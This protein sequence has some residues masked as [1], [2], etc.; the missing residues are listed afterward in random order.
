[1]L[2]FISGIFVTYSTILSFVWGCAIP[3]HLANLEGNT[4][5]AP[6][7]KLILHRVFACLKVR[8]QRSTDVFFTS[9]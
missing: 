1:M 2:K 8:T 5:P 4:P 3:V 7:T 6:L 9:Q